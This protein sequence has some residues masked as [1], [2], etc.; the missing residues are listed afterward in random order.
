MINESEKQVVELPDREEISLC[1]AVTAVI[2]GKALNVDEYHHRY[3]DWLSKQET[4]VLACVEVPVDK[5]T[6]ANDR[7]TKTAHLLEAL[8]EAAYAG[9]IKFRATRDYANPADGLKDIDRVYFYYKR[10]FNW[11]QDEISC[12]E[13]G[14]PTIWSC[15]HLDREQFASLLREMGVS[16]EPQNNDI[17]VAG[18]RKTFRTGAPGQPTSKHLVLAEAKR[19]IA[20]RE[21][22]KTLA[23]FSR[24][25]ADWLETTEPL[26]ASMTA[27]TIENAVRKLWN[28]KPIES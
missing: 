20:A 11:P 10:S 6:P 23:E 2:D 28:N 13:D 3:M 25:L 9:R 18:K 26:A 7:L 8:R 27:G 22:P 1:E 12:L 24:E 21:Y 19:R 4:D 17:D 16:V 14:S 15:V 5:Q